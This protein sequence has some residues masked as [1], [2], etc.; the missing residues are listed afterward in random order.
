LRLW[1]LHLLPDAF[2]LRPLSRYPFGAL[3]LELLPA[4]ILHLLTRGAIALRSLSSEVSHLFLSRLFCC[5]VWR[6]P[7]CRLGSCPCIPQLKFLILN[8]I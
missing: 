2:A 3:L 7:L 1:L 4:K 6:L 5:D 8:A